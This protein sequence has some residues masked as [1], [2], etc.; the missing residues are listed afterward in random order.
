[1][2]TCYVCGKF[3]KRR[4]CSNLCRYFE[5]PFRAWDGEGFTSPEDGAHHFNI[6]ACKKF[7]SK[8][9]QVVSTASIPTL[10]CLRFLTLQR[11]PAINVWYSFDYD[12]NMILKDIPL[13]PNLKELAKVN[14]TIWNGWA[15][16][17]VPGKIFHVSRGS[18]RFSS[19]DCFGFFQKSFIE[20]CKSHKLD[21]KPIEKGKQNRAKFNLEIRQEILEYN[22]QELILLCELMN[23]VRESL[24]YNAPK[25]KWYGPGAVTSKWLDVK[26]KL[27][28]VLHRTNLDSMNLAIMSAYF[29]G[30]ID[31]AA[32][33]EIFPC[34]SYD[35][36]SAYPFAMTH[37][38]EVKQWG[39]I[40][41]P[42]EIHDFGIYHVTWDIQQEAL[43]YPFPWRTH[44]NQVIYP[45]K[46]EGWY[47][48]IE[49]KAGKKLFHNGIYVREG[50]EPTTCDNFPLRQSI[51][52]AYRLRMLLQDNKDAAELAYK[53]ILNAIYGKFAQKKIN[54]ADKLPKY[55]NYIWAGFTTSYTRA[56][57]LSVIRLSPE[58]II[59]TATDSV[60]TKTPLLPQE[61]SGKLGKWQ[62]EGN[63]KT[64][65]V[66]PGVYARF[67]AE[68]VKKYRQR[69][70][71]MPLNYGSILRSWG[72]DTKLNT[73][74]QNSDVATLTRFSTFRLAI[75]RN[76]NTWG[77]FITEEK[78]FHDISRLGFSKRFPDPHEI[79]KRIWKTRTMY[80]VHSPYAEQ[81][82]HEYIIPTFEEEAEREGLIEVD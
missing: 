56:M 22:E 41:N 82:S 33:G 7:L 21:T 3:S 43:W 20:A 15:I 25:K 35:L 80:P 14:K 36:A 48:G 45:P 9:E 13:H 27:N 34:Y 8:T 71:P 62:Y 79:F 75:A 57:L 31:V 19:Y 46:G 10:E 73:S 28:P 70:F 51:F 78:G 81:L 42:Q 67:D 4:F 6:L 64:L 69:G 12:V 44:A 63:A 24:A 77:Q 11:E 50:W 53:L 72:C 39:F 47:F 30:R 40:D 16:K 59:S 26:V 68:G 49:I 5:L 29:G 38:P 52:E 17:Y 74:G 32:I 60:F 54:V 1:M 58:S 37:I 65:I 23:K 55:Q 76:T 66:M 18:Y 61:K 2:N